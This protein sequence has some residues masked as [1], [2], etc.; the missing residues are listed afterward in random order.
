MTTRYSQFRVFEIVTFI[1]II[2]V[3]ILP[4]TSKAGFLELSKF[5]E[6]F[7]DR[8]GSSQ[9]A[10]EGSEGASERSE[11]ETVYDE[12]TPKVR[13]KRQSARAD[14]IGDE[15]PLTYEVKSSR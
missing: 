9:N 5:Y 11:G 4:T 12:E 8:F 14:M 13:V 10:S 7:S 15:S 3:A 6:Y 1:V 2:Q